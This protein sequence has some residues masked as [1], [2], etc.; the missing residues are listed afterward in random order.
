MTNF[1]LDPQHLIGLVMMTALTF[2]AVMAG[3]DY[4]GGVWD[5]FAFGPRAAKQRETIAT[6]I[7][8]IWEANHV[9]LILV[10]V[11]LFSCFPPA[12]AA[13]SVAL[14]IPLTLLLVGIVLRGS[15]FTF[16]TYDSHKDET[17][18]RWGRIFSISSLI[19]P[20]ILGIV[21]G[22]ISNGDLTIS[23]NDFIGSY[24][25]AW[26][27][28]FPFAV[29]FFALSLF[30][31]LAAVYL[32]SDTSDQELQNDFRLRAYIS[33]I[34]SGVLAGLVFLLTKSEAPGIWTDI[35][36][37]IPLLIGTAVVA[38]I[39]LA[40]LYYRKFQ[41]A[42][43]LAAGQVA[44]VLWGWGLGQYPYLVR[45]SWTIANSAANTKTLELILVALAAG[46]FLL[47]PSF[48]YLL[49]IFKLR[50]QSPEK[51]DS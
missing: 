17:Q 44:L 18:R 6:A 10:I 8:P 37:A 3:A 43:F 47:F 24:V 7:G 45:P 34:L 51:Q 15:A 11:L 32:T 35:S 5:L 39:T 38:S 22:A 26:L 33:S 28:P 16:R 20:V 48:Y 50:E 9:W 19:T 23:G 1:A 14:H 29:G 27:Q 25:H 21:V 40:L 4:G 30:A 13:V 2:Y 12:F 31:Y 49:R 36:R 41:I 42:R 46:A